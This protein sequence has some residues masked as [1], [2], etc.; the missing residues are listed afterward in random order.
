ME[1]CLKAL[2]MDWA[3]GEGDLG[4]KGTA[5]GSR[6]TNGLVKEFWLTESSELVGGIVGGGINDRS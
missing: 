2:A 6:G 3:E 4:S 1:S 5:V